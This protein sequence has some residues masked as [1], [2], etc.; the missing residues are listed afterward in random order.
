MKFLRVAFRCFGPFEDQAL[1]FSGPEGF[2]VIFGPN[3]A[4][5]SSALRGLHALLFRFP[6][7][8]ADDFRFK[9]A[10]FRIHAVLENSDGKMLECI[11]RKGNKATLRSGDDK[12]EVAES[13]LAQFLGDLEQ[14]Q[15]EQL[16][17]LDSRRLTEGGQE[18]A[19]G[20]GD[21]GEALFA[22]GAGLAGLRALAQSLEGAQEGLFRERGQS[23]PINKGLKERADLLA[24]VRTSALPPE[25]YAAAALEA[26]AAHDSAESLRRERS[27]VRSRLGL[28][29]RLQAALPAIELLKL[30]RQRLDAVAEAPRLV[31][32][33]Q[34]RLD[35]A[36]QKWEAARSKLELLDANRGQLERLL[37]EEQPPAAVLAEEAEIDELKKLVGA[38]AKQQG[39]AMKADARRSEEEGEAKDIYR[40]LTGSTDWDR[41]SGLKPRLDHEQRIGELANEHKAVLEDV[42]KCERAVRLAREA[43]ALAEARRSSAP[44]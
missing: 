22:A 9:Y 39:E 14:Y 38:D 42:A 23:Q 26:R 41:M 4:G 18:I 24:D 27:S 32:D 19:D 11:R 17:G 2:H 34:D 28:L 16:F 15:F 43:V 30:A 44:Q 12:T 36:R 3:E 10:Q 5:K 6:A 13:V 1:D 29:E 40:Q 25:R 33:F 20:H 35:E 8:S 7:Q 37:R 31:A 21:L